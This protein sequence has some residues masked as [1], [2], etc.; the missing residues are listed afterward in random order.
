MADFTNTNAI[1]HSEYEKIA[2]LQKLQRDEDDDG[3][4]GT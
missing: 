3:K 1:T 4:I 2:M